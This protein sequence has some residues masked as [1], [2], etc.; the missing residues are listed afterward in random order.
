MSGATVSGAT[1]RRGDG[2][3]GRGRYVA[4]GFSVSSGVPRVA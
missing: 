4:G 2:E 3:A 1:V